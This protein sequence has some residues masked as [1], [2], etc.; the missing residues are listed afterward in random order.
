MQP[1]ITMPPNSWNC[2]E[3]HE[4]GG[5]GAPAPEVGYTLG[6][7]TAISIPDRLFRQA[8]RLA[9]RLKMSR[10]QLY[11]EAIA[12]YLARHDS[13]S[14]TEAMNAVCEELDTRPDPAL[15]APAARRILSRSDW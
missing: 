6:M 10:S 12:E 13:E 4:R 11:N 8:E 2:T 14:V 7:K 15:A 3:I 5:K 1:F 9:R